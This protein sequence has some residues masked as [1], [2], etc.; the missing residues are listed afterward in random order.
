MPATE[1]GREQ[2]ATPAP[3]EEE[4]ARG[5]GAGT[6]APSAEPEAASDTAPPTARQSEQKSAAPVEAASLSVVKPVTTNLSALVA[7][8]ET[9][10][11]GQPRDDGLFTLFWYRPPDLPDITFAV[12]LQPEALQSALAAHPALATPDEDTCLA[13]LDNRRQAVA[14]WA[15]GVFEPASWAGA[16]ASREIGPAL[17][18]WEAAVFL[19]DPAVF[20]KLASASRWQLGIIVTTASLAAVAGAFFILRDARR[21]AR[22]ARLKTDFVSSVSHELKTPL[23]SIR[24]FSDLLGN[25]PAAPPEKTKR[26][27]EVIAD[28][29]ARLTRLINNV[30]NFSRM[31]GGNHELQTALLDLR[32]LVAETVEHMRPPLEKEG[33]TVEVQLPDDPVILHGDRDA[34]SQ[35]LLNLLSNA[36][37][38]GVAPDRPHQ[39]T[40][41]LAS[42]NGHARLTV[43]DRGAGVPRGHERRIFE[44]FQRA[45]NSLASGTAGNGLGLTIARRLVEAHGGTL[46]Y[47]PRDGGGAAFTVELGKL[48]VPAPQR[49]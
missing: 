28:E 1:A 12:A 13:L 34:L 45:H 19:R 2:P 32:A 40:V 17:P 16:I 10:I 8:H 20:H 11:A 3:R 25:N 22:D 39:I 24:M 18:R 38:Y 4:F 14:K 26:Y 21:T 23:T 9:G 41:S 30:L 43:A 7:R 36:G 47:A 33:F 15:H 6:A 5:F 29:A 35:V 44:K 46:E 42:G 27:A 49:A 37:K 31:E 48:A